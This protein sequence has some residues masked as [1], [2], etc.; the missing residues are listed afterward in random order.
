LRLLIE[1]K[2]A[3]VKTDLKKIEKEILEDGAA[4]PMAGSD[5]YD[6]M[7]VFIYDDSASVQLHGVVRDALQKVP[8]IRS[9]IFATR[10]S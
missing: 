9:V 4:Y 6:Q 8:F 5:G 2:F 10:P 3:R 7:I 1:V